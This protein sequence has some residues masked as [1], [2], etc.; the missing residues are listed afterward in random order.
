MQKTDDVEHVVWVGES[1]FITILKT[2]QVGL[3]KTF[4]FLTKG[5]EM[6]HA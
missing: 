1:K 4:T 2:Q 5:A 3:I 6:R